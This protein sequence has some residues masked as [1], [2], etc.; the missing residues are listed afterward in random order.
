MQERVSRDRWEAAE[1]KPGTPKTLRKSLP[2]ASAQ[3]SRAQNRRAETD[4]WGDAA[5]AVLQSSVHLL[6]ETMFVTDEHQS[7]LKVMKEQHLQQLEEAK[8]ARESTESVPAS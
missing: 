6:M 1:E 5:V 4:G 2:S 8:T 7:S 3:R